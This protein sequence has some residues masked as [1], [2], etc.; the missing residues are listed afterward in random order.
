MVLLSKLEE[1]LI[2]DGRRFELS[3]NRYPGVVHPDGYRFLSQFKLDPFPSFTYE[4]EG[5]ELEKTVFMI[6]GE[7]ATVWLSEN[8]LKRL[9]AG[10]KNAEGQSRRPLR[11][12]TPLSHRRGASPRCPIARQPPQ[13]HGWGPVAGP[14]VG[15]RATAETA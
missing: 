13:V 14:C 15:R 6:Q 12:L 11:N 4:L 3:T 8:V 2:V 7:N 10:K 9:D 1:T 5:L